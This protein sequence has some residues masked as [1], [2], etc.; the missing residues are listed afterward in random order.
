MTD[1]LK[2]PFAE[3]RAQTLGYRWTVLLFFFGTY[4]NIY[5]GA[6][7]SCPAT[8]ELFDMWKKR[9]INSNIS[10]T[11][12]K[13]SFPGEKRPADTLG[14]F[15]RDDRLMGIYEILEIHGFGCKITIVAGYNG[16]SYVKFV[17]FWKCIQHTFFIDF[18]YQLLLFQSRISKPTN[19]LSLRLYDF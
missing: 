2:G 17:I 16:E 11:P 1:T 12:R 5:A 8:P 9:K 3:H 14:W 10:E 18:F 13:R 7:E 6:L 19:S 4:I 15:I